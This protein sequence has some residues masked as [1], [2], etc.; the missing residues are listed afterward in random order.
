ME[1]FSASLA[2]CLE[3][4]PVPGEFLSQRPVTRSFVAPLISACINGWVN[5]READDLRR[6]RAHYDVTAMSFSSHRWL[7][8]RPCALL[9]TWRGCW[10]DTCPRERF[11]DDKRCHRPRDSRW[12]I[13]KCSLVR[14]FVLGRFI[15]V[16][17]W[18]GW[19]FP[20]ELLHKTKG[21]GEISQF[22]MTGSEYQ[23]NN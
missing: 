21:Q 2:I 13:R 17:F 18:N 1:T 9:E 19:I 12:Q 14:H 7:D 23:S 15:R 5:N 10:K 6:H 4:S 3:N 20:V 22:V 11:H 8:H 16:V